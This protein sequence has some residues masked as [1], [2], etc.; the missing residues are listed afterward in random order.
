MAMRL[1]ALII[2]CVSLLVG[3]PS[4]SPRPDLV[5]GARSARPPS[6][7]PSP[8]VDGRELAEG[9]LVA[10]EAG[11]CLERAPVRSGELGW[12]SGMAD[13][14]CMD[15]PEDLKGRV[16][17]PIEG[18]ERLLV[19]GEE[20][21]IAQPRAGCFSAAPLRRSWAVL[22]EKSVG[23]SG[24]APRV[25]VFGATAPDPALAGLTLIAAESDLPSLELG[26]K[27]IEPFGVAPSEEDR[28]GCLSGAEIAELRAM[29]PDLELTPTRHVVGATW[30]GEGRVEVLELRVAQ[31]CEGD[32]SLQGGAVSYERVVRWVLERHGSDWRQIELEVTSE[33]SSGGDGASGSLSRRERVNTF[34]SGSMALVGR[35]SATSS[36]SSSHYQSGSSARTGSDWW[37]VPVGLMVAGFDPLGFDDVGMRLVPLSEEPEQEAERSYTTGTWPLGRCSLALLKERVSLRCGEA[38]VRSELSE[39]GGTITRRARVWD[40]GATFYVEIEIDRE[41]RW[42]EE[43]EETGGDDV[44]PVERASNESHA[45]SVIVSKRGAAML[46]VGWARSEFSM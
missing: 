24:D 18:S 16:A 45:T 32:P 42:T 35:W 13:A 7:L 1:V 20:A 21:L 23:L 2:S 38:E 40:L 46:E 25:V 36:T 17:W 15:R 44:G 3:C 41:H 33:Q 10:S 37:L 5:E 43:T 30:R 11:W 14:T 6:P 31:A 9:R 22:G 19:L 27:T 8:L 29:D 34:W 12:P 28:L 4:A 26:G 39:T